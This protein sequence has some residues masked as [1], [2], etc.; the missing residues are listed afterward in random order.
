MSASQARDGNN[1]SPDRKSGDTKLHWELRT[2]RG[3]QPTVDQGLEVGAISPNR[4]GGGAEVCSFGSS[5]ECL[6]LR[7][8]FVSNWSGS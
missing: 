5:V 6:F 4:R 1:K 8:V 7:P 3:L 2:A